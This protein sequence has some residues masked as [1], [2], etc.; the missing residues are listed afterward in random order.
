MSIRSKIVIIFALAT[1]IPLGLVGVV[2]YVKYFETME[3]TISQATSQIAEQLNRNLE[4]F[5]ENIN[6]TLD[7][8]SNELVIRFLDEADR[9]KR[10]EYA[11]EIGEL[12]DI[13]KQFYNFQDAIIDINILGVNGNS[14]SDRVG[15]YTSMEDL[16]TNN[17]IYE[18]AVETPGK[19]H[20]ILNEQ[21]NYTGRIRYDNTITIA[22]I[23]R[24]PL[25]K[26][27]KGIILVD[28]DKSAIEDICSNIN[29]GDTGQFF[30][31]TQEGQYI[32]NPVKEESQNS[33]SLD[34]DLLLSEMNGS[35]KGYFVK[36]IN[37][38][39][40]FFVHNTLKLPG[41]NIIGRVKL[42]ELMKSAYEIRTLTILVEG[43]LFLGIILLYL[44]ISNTLT[45]PIRELR[46][47]MKLVE[48]GNLNVEA[49]YFNKDEIADLCKG[50]NVMIIKIKELMKKNII[51]QD[52]L[53]KSEFKAMQAQIN[54]HFL[55]NTLDAI[56]WMTE[57]GNKDE[58]V[59]ITKELSN[60]FKIVLSKGKEWI[61]VREELI[62]I[63]SYLSIQK[64]RYRDI[65]EY[66]I[67]IDPEIQDARILKLTLQ[68]LIE[69]ALY[70]GLKN[71]RG[72]GLIT[73][74]GCRDG[75]DKLVFEVGDNGVGMTE[76]RLNEV[77][78]ELNRMDIDS[79]IKRDP[80]NSFGLKNVNQRIKL[81][82]GEEYGLYID[83][84][85]NTGTC[86]RIILPIDE[87]NLDTRL[88]LG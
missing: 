84:E 67:D 37:K 53:K 2:S 58:V 28:I 68:P 88:Y 11:K 54:P 72:G 46:N 23:V 45:K 60:F 69:N 7:I 20:I 31:I 19:S 51:N 12:F 48:K 22:K 65:L 56:V 87:F 82:Y 26:E 21:M 35:T 77:K 63:K 18:K 74:R 73:I 61:L 24:R 29:L 47:K 3:E 33:N 57:A 13:Y 6:K 78:Q 41:W 15:V 9:E 50:F 43:I 49:E 4:L 55:Y 66:I 86:A 17:P 52:N 42:K 16:K 59:N 40:Y 81:Y 27:I 44:L 62:H 70:H 30:V 76:T 8:G 10:Y 71:K 34:T 14:I 38:E 1:I 80:K 83:S 5:F 85:Y 79:D 75:E 36:K 25:T 39:K 32:Y 64:I